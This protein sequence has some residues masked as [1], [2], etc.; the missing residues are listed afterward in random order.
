MA[1]IFFQYT[2]KG[3][4]KNSIKPGGTLVQSDLLSGLD[5]SQYVTI[6]TNVT[7]QHNETVQFF[8]SFGDLINYFYFGKGLGQIH[9]ELMCFMNCTTAPGLQKLWTAIG[10]NRG[11]EISVSMGPI[12]VKGVL[13]SFSVAAVAEPETH[14]M[15]SIDLGMTDSNLTKANI[16][17]SC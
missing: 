16:T 14:F 9:M 13:M 17:G 11:K 4:F 7:I 3:I 5:T 8:Q 15:I 1:A 10:Q 6:L 2:D 12:F